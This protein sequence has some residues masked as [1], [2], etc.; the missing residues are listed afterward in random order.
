MGMVSR[1]VKARQLTKATRELAD[2][3][4]QKPSKAATATKHFID[5]VFLTP[6]L[7]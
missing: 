3:L 1:V 7:Y 6:R 5:G 2:T 4:L